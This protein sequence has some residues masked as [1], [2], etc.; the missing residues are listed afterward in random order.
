MRIELP[1]G[2][3]KL[4]LIVYMQYGSHFFGTNTPN[5][6][7]DFKGIFLPSKEQAYLGKIPRNITI[8]T[9]VNKNSKN[10]AEDIDVELFSLHEFIKLACEGQT[11]AI[12]MLHAPDNMLLQD[13]LIWSKL[14]ENRSR[15]YTNNLKA[16]V[17]YARSQAAK[18]G[19]KGSRLNSVKKVL[20]FLGNV[21]VN[22]RL[23]D[24]WDYLPEG[25]HIYKL[26]PNPLDTNQRR[27]YQVC[28][29]KVDE[30]AKIEYTCSIFKRFY[31]NYG[32]RVKLAAKNEGIDW[33][34]V[35][36][37]LR[38]AME[39]KQ[40]L[41]QKTIVFPLAEA[42]YLIKVKTGKLDYMTEVAPKL[43]N[44]MED[45]EFLAK[46]S[47]LPS[48]VDRKFW[49]NFIVEIMKNRADEKYSD[50]LRKGSLHD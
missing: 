33:K 9:K 20:D 32:E 8:T 21:Q 30:S 18:Y 37:A 46:N 38:A 19:I 5:S 29:R 7:L 15:F 12:D 36:H 22:C 2:M 48:K 14:V 13:S 41:T 49:D 6:D 31:D 42:N 17:G 3:E 34:A 39:V 10:T 40:I 25:E 24:I 44:M 11:V 45:L 4:N 16:F 23:K 35:S 26:Y 27:I 1:K 50:M 28:G 43:E 47:D